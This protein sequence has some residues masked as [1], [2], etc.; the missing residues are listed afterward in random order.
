VPEREGLGCK[1]LGE[2]QRPGE[3]FPALLLIGGA[4]QR[5]SPLRDNLS[6]GQ[7]HPAYADRP[8]KIQE[9]ASSAPVI[10]SSSSASVHTAA[11]VSSS[12]VRT[13]VRMAAIVVIV[14]PFRR[15]PRGATM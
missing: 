3:Q 7:Y 2:V 13:R 8:G 4:P 6:V 14:V 9:Y 11:V 10:P 1:R 15:K 5:R 12:R